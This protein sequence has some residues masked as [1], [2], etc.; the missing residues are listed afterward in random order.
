M[1]PFICPHCGSPN[2]KVT[3]S[4]LSTLDELKNL[5]GRLARFP[6]PQ[7]EVVLECRDCGKK[8]TLW[9]N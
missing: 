5:F 9:M 8:S 2:V 1:P 3:S 6:L 7:G 4:R